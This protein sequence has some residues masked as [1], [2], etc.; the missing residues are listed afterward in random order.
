[1]LREKP[2]Y[3]EAF[4]KM[5]MG[6]AHWLLALLAFLVSARTFTGP[7]GVPRTVM[8]HGRSDARV[9]CRQ[10][11][12]Q[13]SDK[14]I[15]IQCSSLA[16]LASKH[17]FQKPAAAWSEVIKNNF[18]AEYA[19]ITSRDGR[20]LTPKDSALKEVRALPVEKRQAIYQMK[21]QA[22]RAKNSVS[23]DIRKVAPGVS[24][25]TA[26][27]IA[28]AVKM[29]RGTIAEKSG[30]EIAA[31]VEQKQAKKTM[32]KVGSLELQLQKEAAMMK[33]QK[34][35]LGP[36]ED[37]LN[38]SPE[39]RNVLMEALAQ[40]E[41]QYQQKKSAMESEVKLLKRSAVVHAAP[42]R[43]GNNK[44]YKAILVPG[45]KLTGMIDAQRNIDGD[46]TSSQE[47]HIFEHKS[48]QTRLFK[49]LRD[50]EKIQ[51]LGYMSLVK[52]DS[53][54]ATV[55]CFLVETFKEDSWRCEVEDEPDMFQEAILQVIQRRAGE[56]RD[57]MQKDAGEKEVH[58]WLE[59]M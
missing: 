26:E 14:L 24:K 28:G 58:S 53:I 13:S 47:M 51:C 45:L 18:K 37:L 12:P 32:T 49:S 21:E 41:V 39:E 1:M 56:L 19:Q 50:Y 5:N 46:G 29:M 54:D 27:H 59:C 38:K 20:L 7:F 17:P 36:M 55:R 16:A 25:A 42:L 15:S 6:N 43:E 44:I 8:L 3:F 4:M 35:A 31:K 40:I 10:S 9:R 23:V 52:H 57:L 22:I 2:D 48:R 33:M 30:L 11:P 34:D